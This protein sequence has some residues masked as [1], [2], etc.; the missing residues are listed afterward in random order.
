[1]QTHIGGGKKPNFGSSQVKLLRFFFACTWWTLGGLK[2]LKGTSDAGNLSFSSKR[3][4]GVEGTSR[5]G[6]K[7]V[8]AKGKRPLWTL[9][10]LLCHWDRNPLT[11]CTSCTD[12][13]CYKRSRRAGKMKC[14]GWG[15]LFWPLGW[16]CSLQRSLIHGKIALAFSC[17]SHLHVLVF[18]FPLWVWLCQLELH[19]KSL[20]GGKAA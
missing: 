12:L 6:R 18:A 11:V 3:S 4:S 20:L 17:K 2:T 13:I 19:L 14:Y 7:S 5:V 15:Y 16:V 9:Q 10:C 1:M 8:G